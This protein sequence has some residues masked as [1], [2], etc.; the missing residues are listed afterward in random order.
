MLRHIKI[1][2]AAMVAAFLLLGAFFNVIDWGGTTG[3]VAVT[4][5]MA[6]FE[7]REDAF[8]ATTSP[9]LMWL[10]SLFI[11]SL[12]IASGTIC[13]L[14][15]LKMWKAR[16]ADAASFTTA[17][18]MALS[19]CGLAIFMLFAG[20]IVIAETWY[21]MWRSDVMRGPVLETA[22]RYAGFIGLIALFVATPDE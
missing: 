12:K 14:G 15:V 10:G 3:A 16:K 18:A 13:A 11:L 6:T 2:L 7:G 22:F 1:L 17:K 5:S 4:T 21:E 9:V 19:G 20:W 8:Q